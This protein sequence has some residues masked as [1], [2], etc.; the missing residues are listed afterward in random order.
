MVDITDL[1]SVVHCERG[2]SSPPAGTSIK[3]LIFITTMINYPNSTTASRI[4][5]T[6]S[7]N[8]FEA[9]VQNTFSSSHCTTNQHQDGKDKLEHE[10]QNAVIPQT[11]SQEQEQS[12]EEILELLFGKD[13]QTRGKDGKSDPSVSSVGNQNAYHFTKEED[14]M[15]FA[16]ALEERGIAC[17]ILATTKNKDGKE[18]TK[19][20]ASV[21][22]FLNDRET[23]S[24]GITN[25]N[26]NQIK[27][28]T[29]ARSHGR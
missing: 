23:S 16:E 2:G 12:L 1:K 17:K 15:K 9:N 18:Q 24:K 28:P 7:S 27:S 3:L 25:A 29:K 14:G 26:N 19:Q 8:N 21:K 11:T 22:E 4:K 13:W 20:Y 10:N 6:E 5:I